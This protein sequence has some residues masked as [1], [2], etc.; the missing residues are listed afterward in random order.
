LIK[1]FVSTEVYVFHRNGS[2]GN[3]VVLKNE[4][5][6]KNMKIIKLIYDSKPNWYHQIVTAIEKAN[7]AKQAF[8][9]KI[10]LHSRNR[11]IVICFFLQ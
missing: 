1:A 3:E 5:V 4:K 7:K 11:K 2:K 6:L 9:F 8:Y 10:F